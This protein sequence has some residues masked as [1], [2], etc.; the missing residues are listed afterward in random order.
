VTI[1][2]PPNLHSGS[3]ADKASSAAVG[4]D[5][6]KTRYRINSVVEVLPPLGDEIRRN[7]YTAYRLD[8]K[9]RVHVNEILR[10]RS[11]VGQHPK[12][13]AN[14]KQRIERS[15]AV[16]ATVVTARDVIAGIGFAVLGI[17]DDPAQMNAAVDWLRMQPFVDA[18]R[19][20]AIGS[21]EGAEWVL[22]LARSGKLRAGVIVGG[23]LCGQPDSLFQ[24]RTAPILVIAGERDPGCANRQ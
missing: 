2:L 5:E 19:I 21:A 18:R 3:I 1:N 12:I 9:P 20:G 8:L 24:V 14:R 7:R 13:V 6:Q 23:T 17:D 22:R 10:S 15:E 11:R 4:R 16:V